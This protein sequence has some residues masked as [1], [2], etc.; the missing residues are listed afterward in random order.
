ML[1]VPHLIQHGIP[2]IRG[3]P[4]RGRSI[5]PGTGTA[6]KRDSAVPVTQ[7]GYNIRIRIRGAIRGRNACLSEPVERRKPPVVANGRVEEIHD[8]LVLAVQRA[9]AGHVERGEAGCVL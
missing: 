3:I 6:Q 1:V 8:I 4:A 2:L 9:V 5:K 7:D